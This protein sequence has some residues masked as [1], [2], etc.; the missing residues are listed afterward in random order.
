MGIIII[1]WEEGIVCNLFLRCERLMLQSGLRVAWPA[2]LSSPLT[3]AGT[4]FGLLV[5]RNQQATFDLEQCK[6]ST[7]PHD[8]GAIV[9]PH[10]KK[11]T[12]VVSHSSVFQTG[13]SGLTFPSEFE[14]SKDYHERL[15]RN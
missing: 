12:Y 11:T 15:R 1:L 2:A 5:R 13:I 10:D 4:L 14:F 6:E 7:I 8:G 3:P 9:C